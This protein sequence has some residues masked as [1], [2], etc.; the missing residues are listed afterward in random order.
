MLYVVWNLILFKQNCMPSTR[1]KCITSVVPIARITLLMIQQSTLA[2]K[3]FM[4]KLYLTI[5]VV[6]IVGIGFALFS[7]SSLDK[8]ATDNAKVGNTVSGTQEKIYIALEDEGKVAVMDPT[9]RKI[10]KT[11]DLSKETDGKEVHFMAHNVQV[12]P[13]GQFVAV[14]ANVAESM[15]GM[16]SGSMASPDDSSDELVIINPTTDQITQRIPIDIESH[17]AHVVVSK[18]GKTAYVIS[19][20]KSL[21][22]LINLESGKIAKKIELG[23]NAQPHGLRLSSDDS[24]AFIALI[25]KGLAIL[26]TASG[27]FETIQLPGAGVQTAVTQDGKYA[28]VSVYDTKQIGLL[29]LKT[30][31]LSFINLPT[32][33]KGPVQIYP[34]PDSKYLYVADQGYYFDQPSSDKVYRIDIAKKEVDKTVDAGTAPHG[35]VVNDSGEFAFVTNLLS[36]DISVIDLMTDKEVARI[37]AGKMPNGI[38]IWNSVTGGT[39]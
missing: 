17:L 23:Q 16:S 3:P 29:D 11:I 26:D 38:S 36:N 8:S 37:P 6:I 25:G 10:I 32:E 14:T 13:N 19:Q 1:A 24:K 35:I 21:V 30:N 39:R 2:K 18:D 22:Y 34:S 9:E 12:S 28:F 33:A 20:E 5:A 27:K 31:K 15:D 4:N 7:Q